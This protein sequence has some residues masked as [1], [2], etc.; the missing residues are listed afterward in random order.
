LPSDFTSTAGKQDGDYL[1][2][3][4]ADGKTSIHS[5]INKK[6]SGMYMLYSFISM[7]FTQKF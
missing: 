6:K 4:N 5:W 7:I 1:V 2:L 3:Y